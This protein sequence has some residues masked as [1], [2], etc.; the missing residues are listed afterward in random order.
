MTASGAANIQGVTR[1]HYLEVDLGDDAPKSGPLYLIAQ[2]SIH[3]T[4]S[5]VNV[6]ITQGSRWRAHGLSVEVP[7]GHGGWVTA[8][9]NLGFPAGRKKTILFN[10]TNIFRPGTPRRVRLRTNLEI[11]WDAIHWAQGAPDTPLK[12]VTL[13]PD[14]RRSALSR[15]FG[16]AHAG[17]RR[18]RRK[19]LT[20]TRS[21]GPSSAGAI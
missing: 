20:T 1:D 9:D 2:G 7:D 12:E 18:A 4:E 3:D 6:A 5:S 15:L 19:C 10:L 16:D 17:R 14:V 21:K 8:Q 13:D 11:Y